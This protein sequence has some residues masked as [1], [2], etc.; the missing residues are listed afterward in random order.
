LKERLIQQSNTMRDKYKMQKILHAVL[1]SISITILAGCASV[2]MATPE[3]DRAR[4]TFSKPAANKAGLYV[5][6][7]SMI[8]KA[9]RKS[10][11]IDGYEWWG[12]I[13]NKVYLYKEI[14]PGEHKLSTES[15]FGHISF[16]FE[17]QEGKNY[18]IKLSMKLG[19]VAVASATLD[20]VPEEVGQQGVLRSNWQNRLTPKTATS[21]FFSGPKKRGTRSVVTGTRL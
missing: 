2:P 17:V 15:E 5:Y 4:K 19:V 18:F 11:Y 10:L 7:N 21:T 20:M 8:G 12:E 14:T 3:Q 16:K 6:R 9:V 13:P 1:I